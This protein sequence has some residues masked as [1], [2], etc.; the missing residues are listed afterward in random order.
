MILTPQ[1]EKEDLVWVQKVVIKWMKRRAVIALCS[2][3]A[4]ILLNITSGIPQLGAM[5]PQGT[6]SYGR[7]QSQIR[8]RFSIKLLSQL[9]A[10]QT[11]R[12]QCYF[13]QRHTHS[14]I[15]ASVDKEFGPNK[16][17]MLQSCQ[18][19]GMVSDLKPPTG[20]LQSL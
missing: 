10:V 1:A 18:L 19:S 8:S 20:P 2:S 17:K 14:N 5:T 6:Q 13:L 3:P 11:F 4:G 7:G 16:C 15:A 12:T 9:P